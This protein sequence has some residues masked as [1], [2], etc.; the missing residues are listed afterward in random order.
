ML[1]KSQVPN[2][3]T[4]LNTFVASYALLLSFRGD[5]VLAIRLIFISLALDVLDGLLA[6]KLNS[7][8]EEGELLDRVTDRIYQI[9][10]PSLI[11]VQS[12]SWSFLSQLYAC[13]IITVS[14]W[15]LIRKVPSKDKFLG[16]PL[17]AHTFVIIAGYLSGFIP[18]PYLLLAMAALS[19]L[20]IS[21]FRRFGK[22]EP[23]ET[24]GTAWQLR[25]GIPLILAFSPYGQ[26]SLFFTVLEILV[27]LY[28]FAGW[29]PLSLRNSHFYN[30][31]S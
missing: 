29:I 17:F 9:I 19:A 5:N 28:A 7:M 22:G 24:K 21:Y 23:R 4:V 2:T 11:Y 8:S 31:K 15:R 1:K 26:L 3:I 18:P 10:V 16:L 20:P 25:M 30:E 13:L 6:R 14:F 27:L 12:Q